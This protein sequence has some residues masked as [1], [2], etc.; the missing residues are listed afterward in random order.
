MADLVTKD[1]EV[2]PAQP[3]PTNGQGKRKRPRGPT[4]TAAADASLSSA[5]HARRFLIAVLAASAAL[6]LL[7]GAFNAVVDPYGVIGTS[8]QGRSSVHPQTDRAKRL[9]CRHVGR[10]ALRRVGLHQPRARPLPRR[11]L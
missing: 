10:Q 9:Q 11:P 8:L 5:G 4:A 1:G 3:A 6:M 2:D 7:V